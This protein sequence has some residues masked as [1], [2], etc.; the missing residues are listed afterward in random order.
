MVAE[1]GT[2]PQVTSNNGVG[3]QSL[4]PIDGDTYPDPICDLHHMVYAASA[5][6]YAVQTN[7]I[8]EHQKHYVS[9]PEL[10]SFISYL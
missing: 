9:D 3:T 2:V 7:Y 1:S 10:Y 5:S 6:Q 4:P 8:C